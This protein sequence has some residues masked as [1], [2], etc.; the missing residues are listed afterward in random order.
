MGRDTAKSTDKC[1]WICFSLILMVILGIN[2]CSGNG[3]E[4]PNTDTFSGNEASLA[5]RL[6]CRRSFNE[7]FYQSTRAPV[8]PP[9]ICDDHLI[10]TIRIDV[11]RSNDGASVF[12]DFKY[13]DCDRQNSHAPVTLSVPA[14]VN[15]YLEF[16][17]YVGNR[18]CWQQAVHDILLEPGENRNLQIVELEYQCDDE[19]PPQID[20]Q[21]P[22]PGAKLV[23]VGTSILVS[24]NEPLAPSS[25]DSDSLT[26]W[27][28]DTI[29]E[30]DFVFEYNTSLLRFNPWTS[31]APGTPYTV[32]L[33]DSDGTITDSARNPFDQVVSWDF[34]TAETTVI[35]PP[36]IVAV[37]PSENAVDVPIDTSIWATFS[38]AMESQ[39]IN[40][41]TITVSDAA[42][43]ISGTVSYNT[44]TRTASFTP[45]DVLFP[46]TTY[47]VTISEQVIDI[48][49]L[50]LSP[51]VVWSFTTLVE[52]ELSV[53]YTGD[54]GGAVHIQSGGVAAIESCY[55]DCTAGFIDGTEITLSASPSVG[56]TFAGWSGG[57]CSGT[58]NC[59]FIL[60]SD[61]TIEALFGTSIT[62]PHNLQIVENLTAVECGGSR[63]TLSWDPCSPA[64]D[65]YAV[66]IREADDAYDYNYPKWKGM[67]TSFTITGLNSV[68]GY[69]FVVRA[70][71][72][73]VSGGNSNEVYCPA[74]D[75]SNEAPVADAGP[76]QTVSPGDSV[77]LLGTQSYDPDGDALTYSWVQTAGPL[78]IISDSDTSR[79]TF[80]AP[81]ASTST[82]SM[83]FQLTVT[84]PYG[85]SDTDT[86]A[87]IVSGSG[88]NPI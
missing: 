32:R 85:V 50:G 17:G 74:Q 8:S 58:D 43:A 37:Q 84:D 79:T 69:Y 35:P 86:C 9:D 70:Y 19:D 56:S 3:P 52:H 77:L 44:D 40:A 71:Y 39:S 72:D 13:W 87:V 78:V 11:Y 64:P 65:S 10:S 51:A 29:V 61:T 63:A 81:T 59:V 57:Q 67:D 53:L 28:G 20:E 30:G 24:F 48:Q 18:A 47:T 34:E 68:E 12:P 33:N 5:V 55:G 23:N 45:D 80:Y 46:G 42:S 83:V 88:E 26:L 76:D 1:R 21:I 49:D 66:F 16:K 60:D 4:E 6:Q 2:G 73:G 62:P 41:T 38:K 75:S 22:A 25:I 82:L 54:G 15:L 31:L 7:N 14:G 27:D 36:E